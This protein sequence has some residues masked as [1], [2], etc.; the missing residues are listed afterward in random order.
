[1]T[2][3]TTAH[4]VRPQQPPPELE[5]DNQPGASCWRAIGCRLADL[6]SRAL[7]SRA[8]RR[9]YAD[10]LLRLRSETGRLLAEMDAP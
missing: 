4:A 2:T 5:G 3:A 9:E 1:M 7:L 6:H 10:A 8:G